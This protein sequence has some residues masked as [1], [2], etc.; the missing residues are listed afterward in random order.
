MDDSSSVDSA[1]QSNMTRPSN[2]HQNTSKQLCDQERA[3]RGGRQEEAGATWRE[4]VNHDAHLRSDGDD[5]DDG[6]RAESGGSCKQHARVRRLRDSPM[7]ASG[8]G[9]PN[10]LINT[11]RHGGSFYGCG[12]ERVDG[13]DDGCEARDGDCLCHDSATL[14]RSTTTSCRLNWLWCGVVSEACRC[15]DYSCRPSSTI[16]VNIRAS[17]DLRD[18]RRTL[19]VDDSRCCRR[20][21]SRVS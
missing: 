12:H 21:R 8:D 6:G 3:R 10:A 1:V 5:D 15:G 2:T 11:H 19:R 7:E 20:R 14:I 4:S 16:C 18:T 9:E 17:G 13:V